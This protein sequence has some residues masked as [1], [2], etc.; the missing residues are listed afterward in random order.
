MPSNNKRN[1]EPRTK[2]PETPL[3]E[4]PPAPPS[5]LE[6]GLRWLAAA[7]VGV[8]RL[9][10]IIVA[11]FLAIAV[12]FATFPIMSAISQLATG[13][14][15]DINLYLNYVFT[16]DPALLRVLIGISLVLGLAYYV[17][18]WRYYVGTTGER[19]SAGL[20]TVGY[21]FLGVVAVITTAV[22]LTQGVLALSTPI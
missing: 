16:Q 3:D 12:T 17:L 21:F 5:G 22:W 1:R 8:P 10:R 6:R 15:G 4:R 7:L 19:P 2:L 13:V 18:G 20:I 9:V 11:A 14:T